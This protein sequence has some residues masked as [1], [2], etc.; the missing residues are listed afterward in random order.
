VPGQ[1]ARSKRYA[2]RGR[3][4]T[5][6]HKTSRRH[7]RLHISFISLTKPT[8]LSILTGVRSLR[9]TL[10]GS[11]QGGGGQPTPM[12]VQSQHRVEA[13]PQRTHEEQ[14]DERSHALQRDKDVVRDLGDGADLVSLGVQA[15]V[16]RASQDLAG[17]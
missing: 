7:I 15:E 10:E 16:D 4:Q 11:A 9:W 13:E 12:T 1:H 3:A 8:C 5:H 14:S 6:S 17:V 2:R